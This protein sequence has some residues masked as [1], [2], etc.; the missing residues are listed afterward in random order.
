M[1]THTAI[2]IAFRKMEFKDRPNPIETTSF[3]AKPSQLTGDGGK[4]GLRS[5]TDLLVPLTPHS[6]QLKSEVDL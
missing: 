4:I 6:P 2:V 1:P 5:Q 3:S